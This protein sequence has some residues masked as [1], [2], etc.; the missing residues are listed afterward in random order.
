[1]DAEHRNRILLKTFPQ[2]WQNNWNNTGRQIE[3]VTLGNMIEYF[4]IQKRM[5]DASNNNNANT[6]RRKFSNRNNNPKSS[7]SPDKNDNTPT[8]ITHDT[9]CPIH[10]NARHT[11]G[12]CFQ[13]IR[14]YGNIPQ[15]RGRGRGRGNGGRGNGERSNFGG[16]SNNFGRGR[17]NGNYSNPHHESHFNQ[18]QNQ[19]TNQ[20]NE[21]NHGNTNEN[22]NNE[23]HVYDE[24]ARGTP[25]NRRS[26]DNASSTSVSWA[27]YQQD[28]AFH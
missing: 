4:S 22:N 21:N 9:K 12:Q 25:N 24:V 23:N 3:T 17:G 15:G 10:P 2:S 8:P 26:T 27:A 7:K 20:T 18:N 5:L 11:W 19:H 1:M 13:N 14:N 28:G 16:R 6:K